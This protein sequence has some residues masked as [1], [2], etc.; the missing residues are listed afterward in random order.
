MVHSCI[1]K[2][3]TMKRGGRDDSVMRPKT[4]SS[5]ASLP[6]SNEAIHSH[7]SGEESNCVGKDGKLSREERLA[8]WRAKK[9]AL[10]TSGSKKKATDLPLMDLTSSQLNSGSS[11]SLSNK[12]SSIL[13][14]PALMPV[15]TIQTIETRSDNKRHCAPRRV[16]RRGSTLPINVDESST[17]AG[18]QALPDKSEVREIHSIESDGSGTEHTLRPSVLGLTS[19]AGR[20]SQSKADVT[21]EAILPVDDLRLAECLECPHEPAPFQCGPRSEEPMSSVQVIEPSVEMLKMQLYD[22]NNRLIKC[23]NLL[24]RLLSE[25]DDLYKKLS[26]HESLKERFSK[27]EN[28]LAEVSL[29]YQVSQIGSGSPGHCETNAE[30]RCKI[31]EDAV[32]ERDREISKLR[33][34]SASMEK[35]FKEERERLVAKLIVAEEGKRVSEAALK[36][37]D[38][39]WEQLFNTKITELQS[40]CADAL[41]LHSSRIPKADGDSGAAQSL[42]KEEC[43]HQEALSMRTADGELEE[44]DDA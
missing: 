1:Q 25:Q 27:I 17:L 43:V 36:E 37:N 7:S 5:R 19:D 42:E 21:V 18:S 24:K 15:H 23:T 2:I 13:N 30:C 3:Q 31:L 32:T 33:G 12:S 6:A 10:G 28:T 16:A 11:Y 4:T 35:E 20:I 40:Q 29:L 44:I 22:Q 14:V 34:R 38:V 41:Q 8:I 39:M 26:E 9:H